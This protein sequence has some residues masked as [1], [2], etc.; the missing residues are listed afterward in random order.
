M[1]YFTLYF[2]LLQHNTTQAVN[3]TQLEESSN[4]DYPE[5]GGRKLLPNSGTYVAIY[6]ASF[7][8]ILE[9]S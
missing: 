4:L 1:K 8:R 9:S 2:V 5:D 6:M 7:P 3:K